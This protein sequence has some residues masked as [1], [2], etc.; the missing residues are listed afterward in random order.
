MSKKNKNVD[1]VKAQ[2]IKIMSA[3][4][5]AGI[6]RDYK[7][8]NEALHRYETNERNVL[9]S[10][11]RMAYYRYAEEHMDVNVEKDKG[12]G[13]YILTS[14]QKWYTLNLK[15][16][17]EVE[18]NV[19]ETIVSCT[20]CYA[21]LEQNYVF[22]TLDNYDPAQISSISL[23]DEDIFTLGPLWLMLLTSVQTVEKVQLNAGLFLYPVV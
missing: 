5:Q 12:S 10:D 8:E 21:E 3:Q 2:I 23:I 9:L 20:S 13:E 22:L 18:G 4:E 19:Y 11:K 16:H 1:K 17:Y 7:A 14:F 15:V 6:I